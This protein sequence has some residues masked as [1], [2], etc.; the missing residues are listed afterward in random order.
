M[1]Y[2]P[3]TSRER[4][5][6]LA[7]VVAVLALLL[8]LL[9]VRWAP[10]ASQLL[11]ERTTVVTLLPLD[12]P[13][14]PPKPKPETRTERAA[15]AASAPPARASPPPTPAAPPPPPARAPAERAAPA[16]VAPAAPGAAAAPL[17]GAGEAIYDLD[18]GGGALPGY[19]PPR[20]LHKATDEEFFPLVDPEL[21]QLELEVEYRVQCTIAL[22]A[23]VACRVLR[24]V[25]FYPGLRRAI[26]AA[27]PLLRI[28][29]PKRD[30][31][32][33]EGQRV[34][35]T[36]RVTVSHGDLRLR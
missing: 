27:V 4:G 2:A 31:R 36:W 9:L 7:C 34:E 14:E 21:M 13:N 29:P 6:A 23:R 24:E 22:D 1:A 10:P 30:G 33:I 26:Q 17:P 15:A 28:A 20:W 35:F 5:R 12:R 32:P 11:R 3:T 25:P 8:A 16:P 19:A 18:R